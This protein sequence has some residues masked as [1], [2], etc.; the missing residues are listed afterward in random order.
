MVNYK[1]KYLKY[2]LKYQKLKGGALEYNVEY[3]KQL[4]NGNIIK[5]KI[6]NKKE[7]EDKYVVQDTVNNENYEVPKSQIE[8]LMNPSNTAE[9]NQGKYIQDSSQAYASSPMN[10][11]LGVLSDPM[12][13]TLGVSS[14]EFTSLDAPVNPDLGNKTKKNDLRKEYKQYIKNRKRGIRKIRTLPRRR[15]VLR[16]DTE[17][18]SRQDSTYGMA[19]DEDPLETTNSADT[20]VDLIIP[21]HQ[22]KGLFEQSGTRGQKQQISSFPIPTETAK[23]NVDNTFICFVVCH[24]NLTTGPA[25]KGD[26]GNLY[27]QY[28]SPLGEVCANIEYPNLFMQLAEVVSTNSHGVGVQN[29]LNDLSLQQAV[30]FHPQKINKY[31]KEVGMS[32]DLLEFSDAASDVY[33]Y[34][35]TTRKFESFT[36][37]DLNGFFQIKLSELLEKYIIPRAMQIHGKSILYVGLLYCRGDIRLDS[38]PRKDLFFKSNSSCEENTCIPCCQVGEYCSYKVLSTPEQRDKD[39][40]EVFQL[41]EKFADLIWRSM[42][43]PQVDMNNLNDEQYNAYLEYVKAYEKFIK[44]HILKECRK[45]DKYCVD[46]DRELDELFKYIKEEDK[47]K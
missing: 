37:L 25:Y 8:A 43:Q 11:T 47:G 20:E 33:Y 24:S 1:L 13:N 5:F 19:I 14:D 10:N 3:T 45:C 31:N 27:T 36:L 30:N 28:F 23:W 7:G 15:M 2:K 4:S 40:Q 42:H 26:F 35:T 44:R 17:T 38:A 41:Q 46:W 18:L 34:H 9:W 39:Q 12:N 16:S 29:M 22:P 32:D 21:V 6:L